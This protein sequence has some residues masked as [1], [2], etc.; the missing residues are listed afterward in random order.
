MKKKL[1]LRFEEF[2]KKNKPEEKDDKSAEK[3]DV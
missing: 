2:V 1:P 3:S